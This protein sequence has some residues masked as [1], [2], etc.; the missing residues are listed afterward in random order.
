MRVENFLAATPPE[1][2]ELDIPVMGIWGSRDGGCL[3]PQMKKSER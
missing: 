2:P 1:L 3:E